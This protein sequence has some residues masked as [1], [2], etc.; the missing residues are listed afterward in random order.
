MAIE[1]FHTLQ[2]KN[3]RNSFLLIAVFFVLFI[4][5]GLLIGAV[6]GGDWHFSIAVA[7]IAGA[8][9]VF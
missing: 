2:A 5:L 8:T 6:W 3:R 4:G 1:T 7:V 9:F